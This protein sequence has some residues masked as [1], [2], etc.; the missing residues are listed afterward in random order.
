MGAYI[1]FPLFLFISKHS[2]LELI[3]LIGFSLAG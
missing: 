3:P 1:A 2:F